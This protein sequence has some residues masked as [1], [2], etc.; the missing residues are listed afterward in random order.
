MCADRSEVGPRNRIGR[1][2][3]IAFLFAF[4]V[5][6]TASSQSDTA[7]KK[8]SDFIQLRGYIKNMQLFSFVDLDDITSDNLIHNR[9][10]FRFYPARNL[11][12]GLELRNRIFTGE[13]VDALPNYAQLF[14]LDPGYVDLSWALV[15]QPSLVLVSQVD[16]AWLEWSDNKWEIRAGRQRINWGTNLFW[17]SN[18]LFNAY[19]LVDFDYEERPGVDA[20]RV[21][22]HFK[23]M[24]SIEV[25]VKPGLDSADWVAATM[26]RFNK[27]Q[28]DF[29]VMAGLWNEDIAIGTGWAGNMGNAGFKGEV[30]YFTPIDS[31]ENV[32]SA[33]ISADYIFGNQLFLTGGILFNSA[34]VDTTFDEAQNLFLEP[35]TAK[36]L[37]P[38][39]YSGILSINYPFTPLLSG[40]ITGIYSPGVNT[41]FAMPSL[42]YSMANNWELGLFGQ[43]FF[44]ETAG[45]FRNIGNGV[46]VRVRGSF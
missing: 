46:F 43:V 8:L 7:T 41:A 1:L 15:D 19:S 18:D 42:G 3:L 37:T 6:L 35:L 12:A 14:K 40:G 29:Q 28:Y 26:F 25:A 21:Q 5:P 20:L 39:K 44:M 2:F 11:T 22:R 31:G 4:I 36:N 16:R 34:G 17:N 32:I 13:T 9:L 38:Q 45:E 27:W 33:S 30:T 23:N 24:R 10:N